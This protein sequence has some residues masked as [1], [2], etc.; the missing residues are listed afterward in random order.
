MRPVVGIIALLT[1]LGVVAVTP[2]W[3]YFTHQHPAIAN[4]PVQT[5]FMI[6]LVMPTFALLLL[7]SWFGPGGGA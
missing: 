2:A 3:M 1:F 7:A 5:R 4:L 6:Q